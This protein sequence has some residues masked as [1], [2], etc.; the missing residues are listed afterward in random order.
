MRLGKRLGGHPHDTLKHALSK[1]PKGYALEFG[2]G[3]GNTLRLIADVMPVI[4]FDS[5]QGLPED[6]RD[7]FPKGRFRCTPPDV[8][9][10]ELVVGLFEDTLPGFDWPD[11]IG[12]VHLDAD[13][14]SST[15]TVLEHIGPQLRTGTL[16]VFDEYHGYPG[17]E[18]HEHKAWAE[19]VDEYGVDFAV[20][21]HG[22]EQLCVRIK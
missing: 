14:Y 15:K 8:L 3:K 13:L 21:G 2:V 16:L 7:G 11:K 5:F 10:A 4:G 20:V 19:F 18:Q 1:H 6:W 12:L 22:P 9:N 17:F